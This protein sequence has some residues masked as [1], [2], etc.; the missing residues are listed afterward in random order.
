M[1]VKLSNL[2]ICLVLIS[3]RAVNLKA[4]V[5]LEGLD[6]SKEFSGLMGNRTHDPM[7]D[8]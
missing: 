7:K 1:A 5:R 4:L 3:F 2:R 6:K 8:K